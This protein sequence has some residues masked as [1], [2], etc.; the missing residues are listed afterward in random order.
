MK[1]VPCQPLLALGTFFCTKYVVQYINNK[2]SVGCPVQYVLHIGLIV[3]E[4]AIT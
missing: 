2:N 4:S 1:K 3:W